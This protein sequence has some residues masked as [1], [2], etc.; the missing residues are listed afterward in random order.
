[1]NRES[2]YL[3][4]YAL[5][6]SGMA[7]KEFVPFIEDLFLREPSTRTSLLSLQTR[8]SV[9]RRTNKE[10]QAFTERLAFLFPTNL[11]INLSVFEAPDKQSPLLEL[12]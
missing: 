5:P 9:A 1:M 6:T 11:K 10:G 4:R 7:K 2:N 12:S 3:F 8:G